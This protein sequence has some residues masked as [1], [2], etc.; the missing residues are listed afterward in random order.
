MSTSSH[1]LVDLSTAAGRAVNYALDRQGSDGA[2]TDF[3][4]P[5]GSSDAWM[6]AYVGAAISEVRDVV[7]A[8]T[9]KRAE[10]GIERAA[11]WLARNRPYAAGWGFNASTG[12]DAD[13]TAWALLLLAAVGAPARAEDR[14]WLMTLLRRDG[15]FATYPR[16][17][18]WG[19]SHADVT[20]TVLRALR[21]DTNAGV[22]NAA[23]DWLLRHRLPDG[24]WPSYWWTTDSYTTFEVASLL[25]E[26][27]F[28]ADDV[29]PRDAV[30]VERSTLAVACWA[31][32]AYL[33]KGH[34]DCFTDLIDL[35][36]TSGGWSGG[37]ILRVTD[38]ACKEPW[39]SATGS[40]YQDSG[41][42]T[43]A[44]VLRVLG[45]DGRRPASSTSPTRSR[46]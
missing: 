42:F 37:L 38:P 26:L 35:Q 27:G 13:S 32:V 44:T 29:I 25:L 30:R 21:P 4:L 34:S 33:A 41:L 6:T 19:A 11:L 5:V 39:I 45:R 15:G 46:R 36:E 31:G 18:Y 28:P 23:V 16:T 3:D 43:T 22:Q 10:D 2:W 9:V 40:V 7:G 8:E 12:P 20:A 17:D 24:T 14:A 1:A